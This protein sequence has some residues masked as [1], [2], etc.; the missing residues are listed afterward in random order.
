MKRAQAH[1]YELDGAFIATAHESIFAIVTEE[2]DVA[3]IATEA[4]RR[5]TGTR[6]QLQST[7]Q[8]VWED[9]RQAGWKQRELKQFVMSQTI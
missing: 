4:T 3:R 7:N 5:L 2:K 1:Y 8:Q 9:L 6:Y